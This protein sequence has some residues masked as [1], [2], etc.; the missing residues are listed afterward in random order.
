VNG[1][2]TT[3]GRNAFYD[4]YTLTSVTIGTNVTSIGD[5][6][7]MY[8][9]SLASVNNLNSV[10]SIGSFAFYDCF[11]LR[12]INIPSSVTNI[13]GLAFSACQSLTSVTIGNG[14]TRI[15]DYAFWDCTKL[16]TVII[17]NSVR[18]IGSAGHVG[19]TSYEVFG[20]CINLTSV[21]FQGNA[22]GLDS[23]VFD[24][25]DSKTIVYY[26]PGTTGWG[27]TFGNRPA[28]L[29]NPQAQSAG[30]RTN[31]FGFNITGSSNLVIVVEACTN[32]AD[33][34]WS[35]VGTNTLIGGSS[36]FSD[37]QWTNYP[38]R[39]YRLRSP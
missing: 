5:D 33:S 36:Y 1:Y 28:V 21:Y 31:G 2:V 8:C 38:G 29:W 32:L 9:S 3:I 35:P 24:Y 34:L 20:A 18:R 16:V 19:S 39:F 23:G 7:F 37:P 15:G 25:N 30:V 22:P 10:T 11:N 4:C 12:S 13:G 6:A 26:M 14:V 17:P 27:T